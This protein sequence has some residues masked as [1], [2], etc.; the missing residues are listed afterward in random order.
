MNPSQP[1][2]KTVSD[3]TGET[4]LNALSRR[5]FIKRTATAIGV[6]GFPTILPSG[7]LGANAPSRRINMVGIGMGGQGMSN[8][9]NFL[10]P[11]VQ[12]LAVC[13]VDQKHLNRAK[14]RIDTFYGNNDCVT[15]SDLREVFTRNDV[16]AVLIAT[17]DHW[18]AWPAVQSARK[19]W[20]IFCE[21]PISHDIRE[22][23]IM[24]DEVKRNGVIWQTGSWQRSTSNFQHAVEMI[25]NGRIGKVQHVEIGLPDGFPGPAAGQTPI[26][27]ELDWN[28]WLGPAPWE[29]YRGVAHWDWRWM[30]Q[31]GGG[32]LNDWIGHHCDIALWAL[33]LDH[34]GP[35]RV[36]GEGK[37]P[38]EG[39]FNAPTDYLVECE[40]ENGVTFSIGN[41][42]A[43]E[44][45]MGT[46]FIGEDGHWIHVDR[47]RQSTNPPEL[48]DTIIRPD[49]RS[50]RRGTNHW[51]DF[52]N[53]V[54]NRTQPISPAESA[55]RALTVGYLGLTSMQL[56]RPLEWDPVKE[57]ILNDP[58]ANQLLGRAPREPWNLV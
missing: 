19:G 39:I 12:W 34:T 26:P 36:K 2:H 22:G 52:I 7:L 23:R 42:S 4:T 15:Y 49:E 44:M 21:K 32:Q 30:M 41:S 55:F 31:W 25:L 45:G 54:K 46:R 58:G 38:K 53:C 43:M 18:H 20:D 24:C 37:F 29:P 35:V 13:D 51:E 6:L 47:G 28:L 3:P 48:W 57:E 56:G 27:P 17:P 9:E 14:R 40:F 10:R 1:D 33:D 11:D 16:D 5:Q 8:L 50:I